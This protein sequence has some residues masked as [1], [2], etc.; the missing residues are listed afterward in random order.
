M[1]SKGI[2]ILDSENDI[3]SVKLIDILREIHNGDTFH[4]S[5][6]C[7]EARGDLGGN[8]LISEF[9]KEVEVSEKG[10][11]ISW[12]SLKELS[13]KLDQ[14][15]DMVLLGCRDKRKLRRYKHDQEMCEV[16][17]IFIDM[18]DSSYWE[19]FSRDEKLID[20]LA[21]KFKSIQ[22]LCSDLR[23]DLI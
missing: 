10:F 12:D 3:V 8:K 15:I 2:R 13:E 16:C 19:I 4:W 9:E 22:F 20:R 7:L 18:I 21:S 11:L 6:L 5:I 17:D 1:K 23:K 14:I